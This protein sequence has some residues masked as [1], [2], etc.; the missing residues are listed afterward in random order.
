MTPD[1]QKLISEIATKNH[2]LIDIDDPVFAVVTANRLMLN[3]AV[4]TLF[5]RVAVAIAAFEAS[6][7]AV[8]TH[9]GKV[10]GEQFR[11]FT[12]ELKAEIAQERN[13]SNARGYEMV[14]RIH[15]AHSKPAMQRWGAMA[16]VAS[17][18]LVVCGYLLG[19]FFPV[20]R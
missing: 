5:T 13:I 7:R 1:N 11:T 2:I 20:F 9:A 3:E 10:L 16:I 12:S 19:N 15:R 4:E 14:D 18:G 17:F 8:E 6:A